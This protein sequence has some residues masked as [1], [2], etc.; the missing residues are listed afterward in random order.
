MT[1][2]EIAGCPRWPGGVAGKRTLRLVGLFQPTMRELVE[3]N[4]L[5]TTPLAEVRHECRDELGLVMDD[6]A[7]VRLLRE[8]RAGARRGSVPIRSGIQRAICV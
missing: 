5:M 4:H 7:L 2:Q 1:Q 6:R 8:V 3:M